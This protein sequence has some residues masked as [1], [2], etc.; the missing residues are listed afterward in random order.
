MALFENLTKE[1][2]AA[3]ES[4][5][6][7]EEIAAKVKELNIEASEEEITVAANLLC[8]QSGELADDALDAVAGG[9]NKN[10]QESNKDG[11][12]IVSKNTYC[13]LGRYEAATYPRYENVESGTRC[14]SCANCKQIGNDICCVVFKVPK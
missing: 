14:G 11:Y 4:C 1:Q 3:F 13:T 7:K 10:K 2:V 8:A 9:A 6:S 5:K 12:L